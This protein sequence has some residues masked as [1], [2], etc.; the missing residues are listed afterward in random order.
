MNLIFWEEFGSTKKYLLFL[1]IIKLI[2]FSLGWGASKVQA[3]MGDV[4][5]C[6]LSIDHVTSACL[7]RSIQ[8]PPM[9][10]DHLHYYEL[11]TNF[12]NM[13]PLVLSSK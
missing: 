1:F 12:P 8:F 10:I 13:P 9:R 11:V 6:H 2:M 5:N 3:S 4:S 7:P